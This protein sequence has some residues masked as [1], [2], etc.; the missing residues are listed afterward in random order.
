MDDDDSVCVCVCADRPVFDSDRY[1]VQ[2]VENSRVGTRLTSVHARDADLADNALIVYQFS[3]TTLDTF[4]HTFHIDNAT[5][6]ITVSG[7]VDYE[8]HP[9]Y[10]LMVT[11]RDR[12]S[13]VALSADAMVEVRVLD[14]NDNSPLI[15]IST[16]HDTDTD[17]ASVPA[18]T[19][20]QLD[21]VPAG[22]RP[23]WTSYEV[24]RGRQRAGRR[25][26]GNVL[27]ARDGDGR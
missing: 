13:P 18:W 3:Q 9:V 20:S 4:T 15:R 25:P 26:S 11:A 7:T 22:P 1:S 21:Q 17:V 19:T 12:G 23:S 10:Q 5:G 14:A 2:V 16:L 8:A 24:V 6:A 27:G